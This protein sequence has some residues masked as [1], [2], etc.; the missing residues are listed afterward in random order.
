VRVAY[1]LEQ[2]WHEVP[3]GTAV[4][5]LRVLTELLRRRDAGDPAVADVEIVGVAGRHRQPPGG[6]WVPPIPVRMLPVA[7]PWLYETWTR[8]GWPRVESV[9]GDI[10]VCHATAQIPAATR[11]PQIVTL[12][13]VAFLSRPDRLTRHGA[14]V[15]TRAVERARRADLV[16][17]PSRTVRDELLDH[18][19]DAERIRVVPWGV[20]PVEVTDDRRR[21]VAARHRLP[22]RFVLA[23]ATLEPR[24]NLRRLVDAVARLDPP[25]PLVVAGASGW[26][27]VTEELGAAGTGDARFLGHVPA[28]DLAVLIDL[29]SVLAYPS[30]A[31]GFGLPV[32][33]AMAAGTP[34]VTSR[35]T[36]TEEVAGDAAV[37]VDPFD[38]DA[39][40][41][42]VAL[43]L[44]DPDRLVAAGRA[45]AAS[46]TWSATADATIAMYRE[47]SR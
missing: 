26:G 47:L 17:C 29:A 42:G 4:S 33:E 41:A 9:T 8:F 10:D 6:Q 3:G 27:G 44:D 16:A 22:E 39:I 34:V 30:E 37:L 19:F 31:E 18:G 12:H 5:T 23:V 45:R 36:A 11:V 24:K 38:V 43:A 15:L 2:C 46:F 20:D 28:P 13:D 7:R 35:G 25:T 1:T 32:L 14:A 21:E 40:A